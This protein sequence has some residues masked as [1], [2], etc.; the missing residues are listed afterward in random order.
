MGCGC[1]GGA[2]G[3]G[4][5][6]VTAPQ[7]AGGDWRGAVSA[8][9]RLVGLTA[10]LDGVLLGSPAIL[11]RGPAIQHPLG[12]LSRRATILRP[13][14]AAKTGPVI[15]GASPVA[16]GSGL[17]LA[18]HVSGATTLGPGNYWGKL[19]NNP[20]VTLFVSGCEAVLNMHVKFEFYN[21]CA[22][23][24]A[25]TVR[26][27][28]RGVSLYWQDLTCGCVPPGGE[29]CTFSVA[30]IEHYKNDRP[31]DG[32]GKPITPLPIKVNCAKWPGNPVPFGLTTPG[33]VM[34]IY[35]ENDVLYFEE[36]AAHEVGHNLIS[37]MQT[38]PG[39]RGGHDPLPTSLMSGSGMSGTTRDVTQEIICFLTQKYNICP[40]S[41]CPAPARVKQ[42]MVPPLYS[43]SITDQSPHRQ[44]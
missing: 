22:D 4:C 37:M 35:G 2:S 42:H 41:C 33:E 30:I 1:K 16:L 32:G 6:P 19:T 26:R 43:Y 40:A 34:T 25:S 9:S 10:Q 20:S 18:R 39:W 5:D 3:C 12:V 27:F 44:M 13:P 8:A 11:R 36:V 23:Q 38:P 31:T 29:G 14:Y 21:G 28:K 7:L 15:L 17:A 24:A